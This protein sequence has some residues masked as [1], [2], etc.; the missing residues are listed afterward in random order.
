M[1]DISENDERHIANGWEVVSSKNGWTYFK[2]PWDKKV[3][4]SLPLYPVSFNN[5]NVLCWI[6]NYGCDD[7]PAYAISKKYPNITFEYEEYIADYIV[8]VLVKDGKV[9][10]DLRKKGE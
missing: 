1:S 3:Y 2:K 4:D 9:V 8:H 10:E 7:T 5:D 6:K